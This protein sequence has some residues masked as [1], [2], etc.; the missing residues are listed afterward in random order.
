VFAVEMEGKA[1][2]EKG[3]DIETALLLMCSSASSGL[4]RQETK[5]N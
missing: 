3:C 4:R 1:S 5:L 2:E